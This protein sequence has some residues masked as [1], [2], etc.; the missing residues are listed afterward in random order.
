M[1]NC[2]LPTDRI[3]TEDQGVYWTDFQDRGRG[4]AYSPVG[5]TKANIAKMSHLAMGD[6]FLLVA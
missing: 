6:G 2:L 3:P 4:L 1:N 5:E